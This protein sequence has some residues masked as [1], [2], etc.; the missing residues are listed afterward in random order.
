MKGTGLQFQVASAS[1]FKWMDEM[2]MQSLCSSCLDM[3]VAV[4]TTGKG[5]LLY[6]QL[7]Q[8]CSGNNCPAIRR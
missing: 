1:S 5:V 8:H 2:G 7:L 4:V 3:Q 6:T